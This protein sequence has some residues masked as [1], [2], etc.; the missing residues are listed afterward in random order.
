[1]PVGMASACA[2]ARRWGKVRSR[3]A[4][5]L[6]LNV[7]FIPLILLAAACEQPP[8]ERLR[9]ASNQWPGYEPLYLAREL[10]YFDGTPVRLY[11]LP[12][13]SEVINA[14]RNRAIDIAALTLDEAL[15]LVQDDID[16]RVLL[17]MDVSNG[18][19]VVMAK[20]AIK[21]LHELRGKRV[22]L[23]SFALGAY[24]LSRTLDAAGLAPADIR[25]VPLTV[26]KHEEAYRSDMV[27]AVV[28]FEPVRSRL[29]KAGAHVLFDSSRIPNEIFDVLVVHA[30]V[31]RRRP[32]DM[33]LLANTWFRALDYLK[34]NPQDASRRMAGRVDLGSVEFLEALQGLSLPDRALNLKLLGPDNPT[35]LV[36]ARRL[37]NVMLS[38]KLIERPVDPSKL[39]DPDNAEKLR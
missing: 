3:S 7:L 9:I 39:L 12:S 11:E 35:L 1:M 32:A 15:L 19:D 28:T 4:M 2:R 22:G 31:Y 37:A 13:A 21:S 6:L 18:A 36:P 33:K 16:V 27:D 30:D 38:Q 23:E 34:E 10:G 26:D 5:R 20:P 8:P 24:M 17:V 29:L 14:F 25:V